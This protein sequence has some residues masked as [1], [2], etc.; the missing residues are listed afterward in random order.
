MS[1]SAERFQ[2]FLDAMEQ[3]NCPVRAD[4]PYLYCGEY[5]RENGVNA[6]K[7]A[8]AMEPLPTAV[9]S[10]SNM[11][12]LGILE[13]LHRRGNP[14]PE[15]SLASYDDLP[16]INLMEIQPAIAHFDTIALGRQAAYSILEHI[17]DPQLERR[18][19]IFDPVI[20]PGNFDKWITLE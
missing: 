16:D 8:L 20:I 3:A 13:E 17:Q 2:G 15:L 10:H 7:K 12:M 4:Y 18:E 9:I 5:T 6:V 14:V 1:N 19:Y 11:P